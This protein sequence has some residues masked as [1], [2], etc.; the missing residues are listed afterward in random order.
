MSFHPYSFVDS[1]AN[2]TPFHPNPQLQ[3]KLN[4]ASTS[5]NVQGLPPFAFPGQVPYGYDYTMPVNPYAAGVPMVAPN[6]Q[7]LYP[8][9]MMMPKPPV[10]VPSMTP[11]GLSG[12]NVVA[13]QPS[14]PAESYPYDSIKSKTSFFSQATHATQATDATTGGANDSSKGSQDVVSKSSDT[15]KRPISATSDD[16]IDLL[17][18]SDE[19][20]EDTQEGQGAQPVEFQGKQTIDMFRKLKENPVLMLK[21]SADSMTKSQSSGTF[22]SSYKP[23]STLKQ[24]STSP[25]N[26]ITH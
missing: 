26:Q 15:A 24:K 1:A 18:I 10:P 12:S 3:Q 9:Q 2:A 21:S 25:P 22:S 11:P 5:Q 17:N 6:G 13:P 14:T 19:S 20:E 8:P 7:P 4:N 23:A 16:N